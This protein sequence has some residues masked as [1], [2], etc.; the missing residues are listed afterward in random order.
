MYN[1]KPEWANLQIIPDL[2]TL[3]LKMLVDHVDIYRQYEQNH[4]DNGEK[5]CKES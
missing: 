3:N 5:L 4:Y 2:L 1:L